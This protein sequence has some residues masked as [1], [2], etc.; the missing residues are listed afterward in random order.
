MNEVVNKLGL[1]ID[2]DKLEVLSIMVRDIVIPEYIY[3]I[4]RRE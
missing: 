2:E 1:N 3:H 4:K